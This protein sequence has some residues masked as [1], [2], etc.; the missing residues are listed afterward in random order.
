[1]QAAG[2]P[3]MWRGTSA[4]KALGLAAHRGAGVGAPQHLDVEGA[5]TLRGLV[6]DKLD[7]LGRTIRAELSADKGQRQPHG[8]QGVGRAGR[9]GRWARDAS[10]VFWGR[11]GGRPA[12]AEDRLLEE[13][14]AKLLQLLSPCR[15]D[16]HNGVVAR[17]DGPGRPA[18]RA[19]RRVGEKRRLAA[20]ACAS[21]RGAAEAPS[22]DSR[23]RTAYRAMISPTSHLSG[24]WPHA[25]RDWS[26]TSRAPGL[27][28]SFQVAGYE[29]DTL[30]PMPSLPA[31]SPANSILSAASDGDGAHNKIDLMLE[32]RVGQ[33][34]INLLAARRI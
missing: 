30:T 13:G 31:S 10:Q 34:E 29:N 8:G 17:L 22:G 12:A 11:A 28:S 27:F 24:S 32:E 6:L 21:P 26:V 5:R 18:G 23:G 2:R 19:Q 20:G 16:N 9:A 15:H 7:V 1:M 3:G 33:H 25:S 4:L 14:G